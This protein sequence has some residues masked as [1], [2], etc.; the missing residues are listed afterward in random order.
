MPAT[1]DYIRILSEAA[2][3]AADD[4]DARLARS[5]LPRRPR[6]RSAVRR[7]LAQPSSRIEPGLVAPLLR[8]YPWR[9]PDRG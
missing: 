9:P 4:P 1:P 5:R 3:R 2:D 6:I 8:D 7:W